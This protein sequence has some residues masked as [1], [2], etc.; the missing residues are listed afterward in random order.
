[1]V[2][3]VNKYFF[4]NFLGNSVSDIPLQAGDDAGQVHWI[5]IDSALPLYA[6]HSNFLELVTKTRHAHW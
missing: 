2:V 4:C 6:S 1:M 3:F 5:E